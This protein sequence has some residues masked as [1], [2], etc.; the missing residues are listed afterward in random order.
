MSDNPYASA[1]KKCDIVMK[2]GITSGIVYPRAVTTLAKEYQFQSIGGTSAGAIAAAITAAAE[3]RRKNG[4]IGFDEMEKIP[5]WL[6]APSPRSKGSNL[7]HMFQPQPSMKG[8]FRVAAAYL[9][10]AGWS[11]Y[12]RM[13]AALWIEFA[14]GASPGLTVLALLRPSHP[15]AGSVL[16]VFIALVGALLGG[17]G[18]VAWRAAQLPKN[19]FGMCTGYSE[20]SQGSPVALTAWLDQQINSI[21]GKSPDKPL[22]FGDLRKAGIK[23]RM[24]STCLTLGRPYTLPFDT[25]EFYFDPTEMLSFFPPGV[26]KW[27]KNHGGEVSSHHEKVDMEGLSPMPAGDDIPVVFATRCS[28]SFPILFC[29]V[30]LYSV[31]WTRR[32]RA[33]GEPVP[34]KRVAGDAIGHDEP[35]KPERLWFS[36]G[37]ICS[38]FPLHLFD[39]PL[40]RWPTF[41][42]NLRD[43]RADYAYAQP[44]D[45]VWMPTTNLGGIAQEWKRWSGSPTSAFS[46][47]GSIVDSA[48]NWTDTLQTMVPGYRDR[49]AH[50]YL[51]PQQGGLNLNMP[52]SVVEDISVYGQL[53]AE[54]LADRFIREMDGGKPTPMTWD[55]QRWIRYRSTMEV[56]GDFLAKF[57]ASMKNPERGDRSY[58]EL[59]EREN[60]ADPSCYRL[61]DEQRHLAEDVT[62]SLA[63]LGQE[64]G[65]GDLAK[66][67]PRPTPGLR[68]RPQF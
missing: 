56:V 42:L 53:A 28:L 29:A 33:A 16:G 3:Y 68:V 7:F 51:N 48:R 14:V 18:G 2:G 57:A 67:A 34:P 15:T 5:D 61:T 40:P 21:A 38:N 37:G 43:T 1:S 10:Y 36:D 11:R 46:F 26:V 44:Q 19:H 4:G 66:G 58:M 20:P 62:P 54:K 49:I 52:Q 17:V 41:C 47:V 50:I 25:N 22:T 13:V 63:D 12:W 27:M 65:D 30:P 59:I 45:H 23:L 24:I 60:G 55:N 39:S 31:D 9:G 6:G 35:R 32:R 8:L 64:L